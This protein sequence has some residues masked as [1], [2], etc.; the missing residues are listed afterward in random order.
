MA[1]PPGEPA[2]AGPPAAHPAD[3]GLFTAWAVACGL[4]GLLMASGARQPPWTVLGVLL[5][6]LSLIFTAGQVAAVIAKR[7]ALWRED[8]SR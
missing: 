2:A 6:G 4:L 3:S 8:R 5:L 1:T 7:H